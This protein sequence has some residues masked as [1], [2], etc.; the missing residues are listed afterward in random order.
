LP[1]IIDIKAFGLYNFILIIVKSPGTW[2][3]DKSVSVR[4]GARKNSEFESGIHPS[5]TTSKEGLKRLTMYME[6]TMI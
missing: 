4:A 3:Q 6:T 2:Q 1:A 5:L